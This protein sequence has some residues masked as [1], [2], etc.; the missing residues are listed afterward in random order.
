MFPRLFSFSP[1]Y[2]SPIRG[3]GEVNK[4]E[5]RLGLTLFSDLSHLVGSSG[6]LRTGT[7]TEDAML[8]C[9]GESRLHKLT[10]C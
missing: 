7:S 6:L 9:Y 5:H 10:S 3:T 4:G 8:S 1:S 2:A